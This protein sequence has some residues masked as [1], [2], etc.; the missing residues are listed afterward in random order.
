M[1]IG[2]RTKTI[3]GELDAK[4]QQLEKASRQ[5]RLCL[6]CRKDFLSEWIGNRLCDV[7]TKDRDMTGLI[8]SR[9]MS[10]YS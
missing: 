1:T 5:Y 6:K 8:S 3:S 10:V 2:R 4:T 9:V 7:C